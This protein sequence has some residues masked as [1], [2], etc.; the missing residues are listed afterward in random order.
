[1]LCASAYAAEDYASVGMYKNRMYKW[2]YFPAVKEFDIDSLLDR[3]KRN[4]LLW[5]GR[6]I[7][8]KHPDDAIR[9]AGKLK[10][11]GY[12]FQL[13]M[14]GAGEMEQELKRMVDNCGVTDEVRFLG[15]MPPEQVR[16]YM[17]EAGIYLFT[18]D[19][20]EG[21]GAVLNE[22]MASGCAVVASDAPGST[23]FLVWNG[24]NGMVYRS[25]DVSMLVDKVQ[26]LLNHPESQ[27]RYG[28]ASYRTILNTW[29]GKNA[30]ERLIQLLEEILSGKIHESLFAEG[31]CSCADV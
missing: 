22:A 14:I 17:E 28:K 3:K 10:E 18:S 29:N 30:S 20:Q 7:D 23:P 12:D 16:D 13:N 11:S 25:G 2:G 26:F 21:W 9:L 8:W 15:A 19:R 4:T 24:E 5:C 31:P 1:M 27:R 6:F